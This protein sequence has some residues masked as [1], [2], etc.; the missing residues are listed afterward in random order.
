LILLFSNFTAITQ[1]NSRESLLNASYSKATPFSYG[2]G[3]VHPNGAM[4]P[5]LV[6][7]LT[8]DDYL[9]FICALGYNETQ[10]S[11][12]S[13]SPYSCPN[14]I[15]LTNFNYPS[16]TVPLLADSI[17]VTRT[18]KNVGSPGTYTAR[19]HEPSGISVLVKP[20]SLKFNKVG[21]E[22]SF[23]VTLKVKEANASKDYV[24]G[25]LIWS[26]ERHHVGSPIVVKAAYRN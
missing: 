13:D 4:D 11:M 26:D 21:E 1:D 8:V 9:N 20:K 23:N 6:Y 24:F 18:L 10:V 19:V 16:I 22:K 7:D 3:H 17:T 15:S 25:K 14:P 5:G 2:A 12:F